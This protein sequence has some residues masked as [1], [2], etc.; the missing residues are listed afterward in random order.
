MIR[1]LKIANKLQPKKKN[2]NKITNNQKLLPLEIHPD[3]ENYS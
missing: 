2:I 3:K 1:K